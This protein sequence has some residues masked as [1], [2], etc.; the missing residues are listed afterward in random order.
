MSGWWRFMKTIFELTETPLSN[1]FSLKSSEA[2]PILKPYNGEVSPC[3]RLAFFC[4][5]N[6]NSSFNDSFM[7]TEKKT[8]VAA[9]SNHNSNPLLCSAKPPDSTSLL[10]NFKIRNPFA[11]VSVW[12]KKNMCWWIVQINNLK[13]RARIFSPFL[14]GWLLWCTT[15]G[16]GRFQKPFFPVFSFPLHV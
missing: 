4:C 14:S 2:T 12:K 13:W 8:F 1:P 11:V 10:K 6:C 16:F 15:V 5:P 9:L 7:S 3:T